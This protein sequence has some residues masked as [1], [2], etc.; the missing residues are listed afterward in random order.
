MYSLKS[1]TDLNYY[2]FLGYDSGLHSYPV[3]SD[4]KY[5]I[6]DSKD[7]AD[8]PEIL[9]CL[10]VKFPTL[11]R[12]IYRILKELGRV[13]RIDLRIQIVLVY[14]QCPAVFSAQDDP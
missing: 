12:K 6:S 8:F 13:S 5:P 7:I 14:F 11:L 3:Q 4:H 9:S 1:C 10:L 2:R